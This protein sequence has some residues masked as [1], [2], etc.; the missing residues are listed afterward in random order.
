MCRGEGERRQTQDDHRTEVQS[1]GP[2]S[3]AVY[4]DVPQNR[5]QVLTMCTMALSFWEH[6]R[7]MTEESLRS[8]HLP[9]G[10]VEDQE[11]NRTN[12]SDDLY[13]GPLTTVS[14]STLYAPGA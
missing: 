3:P 10:A 6:L 1:K 9:D 4:T 7:G 14:S 2:M 8:Y 12:F 13:P 5:G 11:A